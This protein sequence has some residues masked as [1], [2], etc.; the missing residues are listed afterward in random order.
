MN[1]LLFTFVPKLKIKYLK[2]FLSKTLSFRRICLLIILTLPPCFLLAQKKAYQ[3]KMLEGNI[4]IDGLDK[5]KA[6]ETVE[7]GGDFIQRQPSDGDQPSQ[8]TAFK[9]LYDDKN[10]YI[11]IRAFDTLP[12]G[13][14]K[15]M[16]RRDGFEGDWVEVNIDSYFDQRTAFSFTASVSGVKGDEAISNDGNNWDTSW[17]PIWYLKTS[18]DDL[19]W[20]AEYRIPLSQLRFGK[21]Q[22]QVWGLQ[23]S[24]KVFR[25]DEVSNWQYV[26]KNASG[27]VHHFGELHGISGIK[28]Q[29]QLEIMPYV[30]GK[31]DR[32]QKEEGNRYSIGKEDKLSAGVDGKIGI[33]SDVTLDFTLNPDFGQV[34]ADP[35]QVNLSAFEVFFKEQR[36]FFVES[37]NILEYQLSSSITGGN[38]TSD[39]LFYSR[40]IG[41]TPQYSPELEDG[42]YMENV[43]NSTILGAFKLTGKTKKGLSFGILEAITTDEKAEID[44]LGVRH[45]EVVEPQTNYFVS[46]VQKDIN[47]GQTVVG[48]IFTATNRK[49][50]QTLSDLLHREAYSG[51]VDIVHNTKDRNYFIS[52]NF[53][54]SKV[55]GSKDALLETQTSQIRYYQRPF[56]PHVSIDSTRRSLSGS[57]GTLKVGKSGGGNFRAEIG[58]TYRSPGFEI[59]DIGYLRS[60]DQINQWVW[61]GYQTLK[62]FSIFKN[63]NLNFNQW[64]SWD[65]SGT[66][67]SA[68]ININSHAQFKNYW[69]V[70]LGAFPISSAVSNADLRGGPAIKYPGGNGIFYYVNSDSRKPLTVNFFQNSY[71]GYNDCVKEHYFEFGAAYQ[72]FNALQISIYP[73]YSINNNLMQYVDTQEFNGEKRYLVASIGQKTLGA[74]LRI[75]Y[76]ITPNL[77]IQYYGQ[78]FSSKGTYSKF[79]Q[80]TQAKA[81]ELEE[82][83]LPFSHDQLSYNHE[84]NTYSLD[85]NRDGK[86][87][88]TFDNPD[89]NFLQFRSNLVLRWEYIPGSTLFIVWSQSRTGDATR[90]RF[91]IPNI[92]NGLSNTAP[93]DVFLIK[94]TYRFRL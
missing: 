89:F 79:K 3:T 84:D 33:T 12:S 51:G 61:V 42:E 39:N 15:R 78:P 60:A 70:G 55:L 16:S 77:S 67:N 53:L 80:V 74:S 73:Y 17:D 50:N 40:R 63:L 49:L 87:D 5:D 58:T 29:K 62:E 14:V 19:G 82:R 37:K 57:G 90:D 7:W 28:P 24:R 47:K 2:I 83:Y 9:I 69:R 18:V 21:K 64:S 6:W 41:R 54:M 81:N 8:K 48:G 72:P 23:V 31:A 38:Y 11:L 75:N 59:N 26:S 1:S 35:S 92:S 76:I 34:E 45:K 44:S 93:Y 36:P 27:W 68:G 94:F 22:D 86:G 30:V 65:F 13:I 32:Y 43:S 56:A 4:T 88:Y 25:K 91:S 46:R 20:M 71:W 52:G 10:L 85:E 66:R